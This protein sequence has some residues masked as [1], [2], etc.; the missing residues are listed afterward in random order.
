MNTDQETR[1][2]LFYYTLA[3]G[4]PAF[5]HQHAVDAIAAQSATSHDSVIKIIFAL[6]GLYLHVEKH[7]TGREVQ[8]VHMKLGRS[9]RS[10]PVCILPSDRGSITVD[11]VMAASAGA[12]RDEMIDRWCASVWEAF[13]ENRQTVID[14]LASFGIE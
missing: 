4:D 2:N 14:L 3:H 5:I 11:D 1:N 6:V 8:R 12:E 13:S 10:W 7:Y 9:K